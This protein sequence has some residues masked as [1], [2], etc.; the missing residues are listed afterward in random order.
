MGPGWWRRRNHGHTRHARSLTYARVV[1]SD[2]EAAAER[3]LDDG[4]GDGAEALGGEVELGGEPG[5]EA[6]PGP[7]RGEQVDG[8]AVAGALRVLASGEDGEAGPLAGA[9]PHEAA[10]PDG[11]AERARGAVPAGGR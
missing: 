3:G 6:P 9:L 7:A 8:P 2:G 11:V 1:A 10:G 5:H 4:R